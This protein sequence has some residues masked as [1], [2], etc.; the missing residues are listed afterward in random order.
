M[1]V[2]LSGKNRIFR[3]G[4]IEVFE[5]GRLSQIIQRD[6]KYNHKSAYKWEP[7]AKLDAERRKGNVT[8]E[9]GFRVMEPQ[10]KVCQQLLGAGRSKEQILPSS[11]WRDCG[12][13][14][15]ILAQWNWFW[16]SGFQN[17]E[18][19]NYCKFRPQSLWWF[20][21]AALG[22]LYITSC[23]LGNTWNTKEFL[24][25]PQTLFLNYLPWGS[26]GSSKHARN[27]LE[28]FF[29]LMCVWKSVKYQAFTVLWRIIKQR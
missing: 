27:T 14:T 24:L 16:T 19:V 13:P 11:L 15:L 10:A 3:Y 29:F 1:N 20:V 25:M 4:Q 26:T 7:E 28:F 17:S 18:K 23:R 5:M 6:M 9:A 21:T 12:S 2:H 8:E 22:K